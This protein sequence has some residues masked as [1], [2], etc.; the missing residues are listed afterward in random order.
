MSHLPWNSSL[1]LSLLGTQFPLRTQGWGIKVFWE[2][3]WSLPSLLWLPKGLHCS[4][5]ESYFLTLNLVFET[6]QSRAKAG[7]SE[8]ARRALRRLLLPFPPL[9]L[10]PLTCSTQSEISGVQGSDPALSTDNTSLSSSSHPVDRQTAQAQG[11][12]SS[13]SGSWALGKKGC[14]GGTGPKPPRDRLILPRQRWST[15]PWR[16]WAR[17]PWGEQRQVPPSR[18]FSHGD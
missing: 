8:G 13:A 1:S 9:G 3:P 18:A 5:F 16:S 4:G 2:D 11:L 7:R 12:S 6:Q 10:H 17:T 14:G 15:E